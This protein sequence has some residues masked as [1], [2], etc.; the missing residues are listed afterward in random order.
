MFELTQFRPTELQRT[1]LS[2]SS[3][4]ACNARVYPRPI[5]S[6]VAKSSEFK[7]RVDALA[8]A[9]SLDLLPPFER[10]RL[11]KE[12]IREAAMA[13]RDSLTLQINDSNDDGKLRTMIALSRAVWRGSGRTASLIRD[14]SEFA[15]DLVKV[16]GGVPTL[17]SATDF[18][19]TLDFLQ[20]S[21]ISAQ[22]A[23]IEQ[24]SGRSRRRNGNRRAMLSRR[25]KLWAPFDKRNV[26]SGIVDI[27]NNV[28]RSP[29]EQAKAL[30]GF[31]GKIHSLAEFDSCAADNILNNPRSRRKMSH[32]RGD[33]YHCT[34]E[35]ISAPSPHQM[36]STNAFL[37]RQWTN[38]KVI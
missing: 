36:I 29:G 10:L 4:H 20:S 15:R 26:L 13:A 12:I 23:N 25:G 33:H 17:I 6:H 24:G 38:L 1:L 37:R 35:S 30:G 8:Y 31:W 21:N 19:E 3:T 9:A 16:D 11:H 27:D 28:V 5:Q 34:D 18:A 22:L 32:L 14:I 7:L 2:A